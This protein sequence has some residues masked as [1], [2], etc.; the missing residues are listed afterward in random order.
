VLKH[1]LQQRNVYYY[2]YYYY[3]CYHIYGGYL[4]L[5]KG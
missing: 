5:Y 4:E 3:T 1:E 2:Y